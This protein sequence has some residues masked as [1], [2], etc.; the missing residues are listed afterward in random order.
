MNPERDYITVGVTVP[1]IASAIEIYVNRWKLFT[2]SYWHQDSANL[3][4]IGATVPLKLHLCLEGRKDTRG[5][6][7]PSGKTVYIA[8]PKSDF[9]EWVDSTFGNRD[10][11]TD[12]PWSS[13]VILRDPIGHMIVVST[14]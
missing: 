7:I 8:F 11:V 6:S 13:D 4:A 1:D 14:P 9:W 2:V 12:T 5:E 3:I 10:L